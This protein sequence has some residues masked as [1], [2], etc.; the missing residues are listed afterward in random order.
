MTVMLSSPT[1]STDTVRAPRCC[2]PGVLDADAVARLVMLDPDGKIGLL[3]RVLSTYTQSLQR[4]LAQLQTARSDH[5]AQGQRHVA[6]TL[7]SSS[8][9]VGA[10]ALS[11][12]CAD[13]ER[14]LRD[15]PTA[16]IDGRLD[17]LVSEGERV[18][19]ALGDH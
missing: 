1:E 5:D 9:S 3:D 17:S 18:L 14:R 12:L 11:A 15:G 16:D 2:P 13:V 19:A 6:H 8:A 7:K 4:L 10:L